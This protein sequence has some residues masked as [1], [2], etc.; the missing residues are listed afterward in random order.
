MNNWCIC[1][2]FTCTLTKCTVQDEKS[3]VKNLVRQ[4]CAEGFNSDI[5]WLKCHV[6]SLLSFTDINMWSIYTKCLPDVASVNKPLYTI[7]LKRTRREWFLRFISVDTS[8]ILKWILITQ[9]VNAYCIWLW[10]NPVVRTCECGNKVCFEKL[11]FFDQLQ[12]Y[13]FL[14]KDILWT[15]TL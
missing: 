10:I 12:E 7:L 11:D 15:W 2:F 6:T 3:P 4:R 13:I 5:K 14:N 9:T 1:W 8:L